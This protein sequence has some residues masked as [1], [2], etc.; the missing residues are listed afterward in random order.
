MGVEVPIKLHLQ[1]AINPFE[2]E[3]CNFT[4]HKMCKL[5]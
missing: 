5:K 3:G 4:G 2:I 1:K